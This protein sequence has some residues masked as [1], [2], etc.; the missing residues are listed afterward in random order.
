MTGITVCMAALFVRN[1]IKVWSYSRLL[2]GLNLVVGGIGLGYAALAIAGVEIPTVLAW[3]FAFVYVPLWFVIGV[4]AL[5][6]GNRQA[7]LFLA[8]WA[9]Y[10]L[11]MIAL[12]VKNLGVGHGNFYVQLLLSN[13]PYIGLA[14][15]SLLA[16]DVALVRAAGSDERQGAPGD[17]GDDGRSDGNPEPPRLQRTL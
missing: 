1:F 4:Y 2:D 13:G 10:M 17:A 8:A 15:E 7:K 12:D 9:A 3:R 6:K 16:L 11:G 5:I 14:V